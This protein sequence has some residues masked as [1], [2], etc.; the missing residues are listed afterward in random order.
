MYALKLPRRRVQSALQINTKF[1]V[2][3]IIKNHGSWHEVKGL[4][5]VKI[6][7]TTKRYDKHHRKP[8]HDAGPLAGGFVLQ[9]SD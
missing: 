4:E 8:V 3:S 2:E 7:E 9:K 5:F 6:A 1:P